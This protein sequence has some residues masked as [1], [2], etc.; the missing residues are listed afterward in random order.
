MRSWKE[1]KCLTP[2]KQKI[3]GKTENSQMVNTDNQLSSKSMITPGDNTNESYSDTDDFMDSS[4]TV[5]QMLNDA[6]ETPE[7]IESETIHASGGDKSI[8]V[9]N[10]DGMNTKH[11]I[12]SIE[13]RKATE[14]KKS[15]SNHHML[16]LRA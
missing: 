14:V 12:V 6:L 3:I 15:S 8:Q 13:V 9:E 10:R 4:R 16:S 1:K 11:E 2:M 7:G 5:I